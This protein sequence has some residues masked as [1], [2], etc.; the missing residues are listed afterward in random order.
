MRVRGARVHNLQDVDV[1]I[2][3][4]R[5]TVLTGPSGSGKSSLAF[6]TIYAEGQRQYIESL[7]V[8]ARQFLHQLER[9]DV[10]LI[11]GLQPTIC[12]DQRQ[13]NQNPRSTVATVTEIY[14][15]LRLLMARLGTP[16][17][18]QCG[19]AIRQQSLEQIQ[20]SLLSLQ[21]GCRVMILAPLVRGRRGQQ[22]EVFEQIR[23]AGF[24]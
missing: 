20:Q 24:V 13:G 21:D 5:L 1:D 12:I 8:Y 11:E 17:C 6:D 16:S 18:Y 15:Y 3:R 14:D 22:K 7:S 9:P 4:N 23:Q 2:P 10:D 19:A